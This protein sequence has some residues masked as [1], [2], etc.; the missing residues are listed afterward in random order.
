MHQPRSNLA[1]PLLVALLAA[2]CVPEPSDEPICE[3]G[4]TQS[5]VCAGRVAGV[6]S[7]ADDGMRWLGCDCP[8]EGYC[9]LTS[10]CAEH[11]SCDPDAHT[12]SCETGYH[13]CADKP[14]K[15]IHPDPA[16]MLACQKCEYC[17]KGC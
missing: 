13:D 3:T 14:H 9:A 11:Q 12:C 16:E 6:Q 15:R 10:D 1:A 2:G 4:A 8:P 5:C 17:Q 7:C